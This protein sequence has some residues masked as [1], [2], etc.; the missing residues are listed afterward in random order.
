MNSDSLCG[1]MKTVTIDNPFGAPVYY[2]ETVSSTMDEARLLAAGGADHGTVICAGF[3]E[4]GRG[5]T[6]G[7]P[8]NA[9]R[10]KNLFCTILLRCG[11]FAA[12]PRA[13]TLRT[14]LA[15]SLAIEDAA[16]ALKDRVLVKWPNDIM[17]GERKAAGILTEGDGRVVYIGIGVNV[18]QTDFSG[19]LRT[20]AVSIVLA[21]REYSAAKAGAASTPGSTPGGERTGQE[22][23]F[24]LLERILARLYR[25][26]Q[27][28]GLQT[29]GLTAPD[30]DGGAADGF[31]GGE[32]GGGETGQWR[33]H[34]EA[35]LFRRG[36]RVRFINGG[37]DMGKP[38]EGVL[39]GIGADG[40]LLII[41][42]SDTVPRPFI[43][44]ELEVYG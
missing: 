21:Q 43:T 39:C 13:L 44:G 18:G 7:R 16:P 4:A 15:V 10:G 5:R 36:S 1:S 6:P 20:K 9:D 25:E 31:S 30:R 19:A 14:G 34:L 24:L 3:Q 38:V 28:R 35:R 40:E 11:D 37:A 41:P 33:Q 23:C 2:R 26:L 22:A 17:I 32:G 29:G 42:D 12:I 27:T 8:W